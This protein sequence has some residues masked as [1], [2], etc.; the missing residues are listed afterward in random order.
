VSD[1]KMKKVDLRKDLGHLYHPSAK[2]VA[3][4]DVPQ[5]RFLMVDGQGDP[6]TSVAYQEAVATLYALSYALKFAIKEGEGVD[7]AV[8]PLEG[9]WWVDEEGAAL[10]DI[11]EDR[12]RWKWT[13]MI[14]QPEWVTEGRVE[15]TLASVE[16]EKKDLPALRRVRFEA[17]HE[18]RAAQ[19]MHVGPHAEERP[20][21]ERVDR[22]IE[23]RGARMRGKHH[24][25]YLTDPS[26][27]APK[28]NKTVIRHP[29]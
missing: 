20:T 17:F 12:D 9:L 19:V 21:I 27:T 2:E 26:R 18:G 6:A 7:Y 23:E 13:S 22:F 3:E 8:M 1:V 28:K 4:V 16:K 11:M 10:E 29:I 25:I 15:R 5:M 14:M 24:E